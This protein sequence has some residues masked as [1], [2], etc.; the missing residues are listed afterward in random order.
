MVFWGIAAPR[1]GVQTIGYSTAMPVTIGL[2][3]AAFPLVMP[4]RP[5]WDGRRWRE[6]GQPCGKA[7]R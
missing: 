1:I 5:K 7:P 6:W 4:P 2:W 3:L